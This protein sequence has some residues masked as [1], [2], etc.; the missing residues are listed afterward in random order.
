MLWV[1]SYLVEDFGKV[2]ADSEPAYLCRQFR[3]GS[4]PACQPVAAPCGALE[5]EPTD[6]FLSGLAELPAA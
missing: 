3:A 1:V 6:P 2:F 4:R 5:V